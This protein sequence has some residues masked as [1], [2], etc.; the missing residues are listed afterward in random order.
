MYQP[1]Y[2]VCVTNYCTR[3]SYHHMTPEPPTVVGKESLR[4][5]G[6]LQSDVKIITRNT[7]QILDPPSPSQKPW[8]IPIDVNV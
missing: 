3:G 8:R 2:I 1:G 7:C 5:I 6:P 4:V